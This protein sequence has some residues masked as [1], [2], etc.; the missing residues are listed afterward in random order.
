MRKKNSSE[1]QV[2]SEIKDFMAMISPSIIKFNTD[3][4]ICGNTFRCIWALREY[5][6]STN[7][8]AILRH[9]GEKD[10]ITLRIYTRHV[11]PAE[12]K[13]IISN[14]AN[15]N[16]MRRSNTNDLQETVT[17]ESNLQ[18]V[19]DIVAK[20][21][22]NKEPLLHT[23]VYLE[24]STNDYE[25]LKMLQTEVL[26]EL[27][28]SKLNVD[29][30]L[31]RQKQGFMSV[32]PSG[33]NCFGNQFER[34]L[35]ATSVANL[36]PFNYSGK[37]DEKG[38]YLGRDKFGSNI[39]AD[40]DKR[41]DDKTNSNIL[42]LGNS[43]QGKSYLLKLLLTC[44]RQSGKGIICLDPEHEYQEL[45]ENLGGCFI[46]LMSG[47]YIINVLEPKLWDEGGEP[48][49]E[50]GAVPQAFR[51]G[52]KLSQHISF[53]KD[54]F[55]TYKD[56]TDSQIDTI[57]IML[58]KLYQQYGITDQ[59]DFKRRTPASYPVL[60][61]LYRLIEEEY[62]AFDENERQL[63]T[64]DLLQETLLGLHSMCVGAESKF[65]NGHTNITT[66][67][68]ITFGVKGLLQASKNIKNALLFNVLSFMSDK[69]L[70]DGNTV[71]SIDEFYLFLSNLTAVEYIRN[72]MK[73]VRKK[74]SAVILASQNLEDYNLPGIAELTKP[75]FAI[76]TH[77]FLFN[78]G[79]IDAKFYMDT[80]QVEQSEYNL[81]RFPQ[82][83]VCLFR[84]GNER[85]NLVVQAPEYK[86]KL[87]GNAGGR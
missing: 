68:L 19:V 39:I 51:Q 78:A 26:T 21:H 27:V 76:P 22:R 83:G 55:R 37:T 5:P 15:K 44:L 25:K 85:Y 38:F 46:D 31:L 56:F 33:Y 81:I 74:D 54:F 9:L 14:A 82:R 41:S 6:T 12:E 3:H 67:R 69:L 62:K 58:G 77:S 35:P 43:G 47:K 16:R 20:M 7:E 53:L 8:Q 72:F 11:T 24:L 17:A 10:G 66:D 29:R 42:I 40:F 18:D 28:R 4:V 2:D 23:A 52:S 45:T 61:D 30:L 36:Y 32:M 75:L 65:F 63:Y 79:N 70:S 1:A 34:V 80:L 59:T 64:T 86:A 60:S 73:R 84:C 50:D 49:D 57:E 71:A 13:K 48:E 87:F